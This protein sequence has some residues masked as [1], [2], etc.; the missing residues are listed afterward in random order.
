MK[1][2]ELGPK[3]EKKKVRPYRMKRRAGLRVMGEGKARRSGGQGWDCADANRQKSACIKKYAAIQRATTAA[4][5]A[6]WCRSNH[7]RRTCVC[8]RAPGGQV[9][10]RGGVRVRGEGCHARVLEGAE[11]E[12]EVRVRGE[13]GERGEGYA[14]V[15]EGVEAQTEGEVEGEHEEEPLELHHTPAEA[16]HRADGDVVA[17]EGD[18]G[19]QEHLGGG[20]RGGEEGVRAG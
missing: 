8:S 20:T 16:I 5:A 19:E 10:E 7:P 6:V 3:L 4:A 18:E 17:G 12:D 14:R 15:L 11:S 9:R 13:R 2:V 1:V